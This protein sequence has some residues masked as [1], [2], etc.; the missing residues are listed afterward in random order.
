MTGEPKKMSCICGK[1]GKLLKGAGSPFRNPKGKF[2]LQF[3]VLCPKCNTLNV[4]TK[5]LK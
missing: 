5:V 3:I 1:C 4:K 2:G